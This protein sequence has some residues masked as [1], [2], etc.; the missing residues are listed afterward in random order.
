MNEESRPGQLGEVFDA[1]LAGLS[2]RMKRIGEQQQSIDQVRFIGEEHC[3]LASTVG[4]TAQIDS[5]FR[6]GPDDRNRPAQ[7]VAIPFRATER[8]RTVGAGASKRQVKPQNRKARCGE[9]FG[10]LHQEFRLAICTR[11]VGEHHRVAAWSRGRM[12]E[13]AQGKVVSGIF[14]ER[15]E[16]PRRRFRTSVYGTAA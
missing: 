9:R 7:P 10:Y 12:Q 14:V 5:A 3:G 6:S 11:P 8:W 4:M 16:H 1:K 13:T 15:C 2:R